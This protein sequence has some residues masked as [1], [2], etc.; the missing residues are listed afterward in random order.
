MSERKKLLSE[1]IMP[2]AVLDENEKALE[3]YRTFKEI[4]DISEK[5]NIAMGRKK[6]YKYSTRS[7]KNCE[8]TH[9]AISTTKSY[10]I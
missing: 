5:I 8:I 3:F 1:K 9:H 4:S 10:K 2:Q 6:T 7:T